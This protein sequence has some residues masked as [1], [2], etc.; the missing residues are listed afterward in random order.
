MAD[1]KQKPTANSPHSVKCLTE[2][3]QKSYVNNILDKFLDKYVCIDNDYVSEDGVWS[4]GVNIIRSFLVLADIKDAVAIG[5]GEYLSILRKQL[6]VHFFSN[7]GFN[8]FSIEMFINIL[9]CNVLLSE[10]EAEHC[11]WA[12]TVNW[13][14]GAGKNIE[15]DLFQENRNAEMK[16]LIKSMGANKMEKAISRASKAL[17]GVSKVVEAFESQ[18]NITK[19]SSA[20]SHRSSSEDEKLIS[21]DL[22][23]LRPFRKEDGRQFESFAGVSCNPTNSFN[24]EKF[25]EWIEKHKNNIIMSSWEICHR[26]AKILLAAEHKM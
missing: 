18:V 17:G 16:E 12:A 1:T 14:G 5:N 24:K 7:P 4:Y 13:K 3:Y 19:K 25:K 8:E 20:H 26:C 15:I 22:R 10:A 9:Q 2:A 11:K 21:R 23:S 6:L